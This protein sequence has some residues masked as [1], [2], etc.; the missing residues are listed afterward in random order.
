MVWA[1]ICFNGRIGWKHDRICVYRDQ[2]VVNIHATI[3]FQFIFIDDNARPHQAAMVLEEIEN[4]DSLH[5]PLPPR[6]PDLNLIERTWDQ[7]QKVIDD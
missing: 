4:E 3:D 1:G 7:L 6:S 2:A 5:V